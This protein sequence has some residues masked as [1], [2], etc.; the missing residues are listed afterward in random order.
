MRSAL[1]ILAIVAVFGLTSIAW[2]V[3]GGVMSNRSSSQSSELRNRVADL[4]GQPQA[5]AGPALSFEWVVEKTVKRTETVAGVERQILERVA[6]TQKREV[7]FAS[8]RID[9]DLHLD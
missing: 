2:L 1:R 6:E 9:A 5:Q 3:L 7:S 4:W 8:T